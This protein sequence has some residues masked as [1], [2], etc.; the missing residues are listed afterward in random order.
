MNAKSQKNNNFP[1]ISIVLIVFLV[2][3]L[4]VFLINRGTASTVKQ[5]S[6]QTPVSD[7]TATSAPA[8]S[9]MSACNAIDAALVQD[10]LGFSV[11]EGIAT[12]SG[13]KN[14][15]AC[16][17]KDGANANINLQIYPD[18]GSYDPSFFG[19]VTT[20]NG[21]GDKAFVQEPKNGNSIAQA[22]K[23]G[24]IVYLTIFSNSGYSTDQ[25]Q[26]LLQS[27]VDKI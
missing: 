20:L 14:G 23:K 19:T 22:V 9:G 7:T 26:A 24:Q 11:S 17:L 6:N 5:P 12:P 16:T 15:T 10:K 2:L 4:L 18:D 1:V 27:I 21:I 13:Y 3:L 8:I 25:V